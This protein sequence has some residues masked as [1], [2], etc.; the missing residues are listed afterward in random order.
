MSVNAWGQEFRADDYHAY[1]TAPGRP[2]E[3]TPASERLRL[4]SG[5][6]RAP[7][8]QTLGVSQQ[9]ERRLRALAARFSP[10]LVPTNFSVPRDVED[11]L[12]LTYVPADRKVY[13]RRSFELMVDVW[14]ITGSSPV[15]DPGSSR[16]VPLKTIRSPESCGAVGYLG[17]LAAPTT[18]THFWWVADTTLRRLLLNL[19]PKGKADSS[20]KFGAVREKAEGYTLDRRVRQN[21]D[22]VVFFDMPGSEQATWREAHSQLRHLRS[23]IYVHPFVYEHES[24]RSASRYEL[25]FQYWFFYPFNDGVNND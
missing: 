14:K 4:F 11:M 21:A 10:I 25:V 7:S 20:H 16:Q 3:Q 5:Q 15:L 18:D 9:R 12:A 24:A 13:C 8:S 22:T 2:T 23:R 6:D 1:L 19:G 17:Y